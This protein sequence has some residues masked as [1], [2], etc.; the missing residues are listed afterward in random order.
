MTYYHFFHPATSIPE[1]EVN[2]TWDAEVGRWRCG[3]TA[4][5][6]DQILD[7]CKVSCFSSDT[8]FKST[9]VLIAK[10][11]LYV[12]NTKAYEHYWCERGQK[13]WE[14]ARGLRITE[15]DARDIVRGFMEPGLL[16]IAREIRILRDRVSKSRK[17]HSNGRW[18]EEGSSKY[19]E[20][21][22]DK[23]I[24]ALHATYGMVWSNWL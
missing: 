4:F 15:R 3:D 17:S 5:T 11:V 13:G 14:T 24:A 21:K 16:E 8:D 23:A 19:Y 6:K 18:R 20:A 12:Q 10:V 22:L 7:V 9:M 1:D 2:K